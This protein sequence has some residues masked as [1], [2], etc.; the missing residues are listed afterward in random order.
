MED[1]RY[2]HPDNLFEALARND[3][4]SMLRIYGFNADDSL[5]SVSRLSSFHHPLA[6]SLSHEEKF[7]ESSQPGQRDLSSTDLKCTG[8]SSSQE[9]NCL[10]DTLLEL[11]AIL[12]KARKNNRT[13]NSSPRDSSAKKENCSEH[14]DDDDINPSNNDFLKEDSRNDLDHVPENRRNNNVQQNH[15]EGLPYL[16]SLSLD[17]TEGSTRSAQAQL[18]S[19]NIRNFRRYKINR[20]TKI[21]PKRRRNSDLNSPRM[22]LSQDAIENILY[23]SAM[24]LS[25]A[26]PH[27]SFTVSSRTASHESCT[28]EHSSTNDHRQ[29]P[30]LFDGAVANGTPI[31][32]AQ[33]IGRGGG[34]GTI[35]HLACAID[36]PF[37]LA[38]V[39]VM[40]ADASSRHT[41]FRRLIIHE[42]ACCDSPKCLRL[43][44]EIGKGHVSTV[45]ASETSAGIVKGKETH[46]PNR[47]MKRQRS[48]NCLR[49]LAKADKNSSNLS[50]CR[51]P[52]T[53]LLQLA[54]NLVEEI[55]NHKISDLQAAR[56]L[57]SYA[58]LNDSNKS[59][60]SVICNVKQLP[61]VKKN[62]KQTF[63]HFI[64][65]ARVRETP[66]LIT[67]VDGHG[68][69]A[70]HWA[71]FKNSA[72][73]VSLL[74]EYEADPNSVA[75][76]T[77]WTP[78]HDAAYSDS[79]DS[80]SILVQSGANVNA[81]AHSGATP[82]CF[83]AQEDS[84]NAARLLIDNG[85]DPSLRCCENNTSSDNDETNLAQQF[86][87]QQSRFSGYTPLH[88]CAHYNSHRAA[89]VLLEYNSR[90]TM[91]G[92]GRSLL[93]IP[94]LNDKLAIHIVAER[95]SSEVLRELLHSGARIDTS[96]SSIERNSNSVQLHQSTTLSPAASMERMDQQD[97]EA[98]SPSSPRAN[99]ASV[100]TP[101]SS[102][103]LRSLI[104]SE[105]VRSSKPWNCLSQ[106]S[107]DE[108][109][110]LLQE[111]ESFWEPQR[112]YIFPTCDRLSIYEVLRVG[113]RLNFLPQ[114]IWQ[115]ILGFCGRGW[116]DP[117]EQISSEN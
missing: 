107:I 117:Y 95:G 6:F 96:K 71:S 25:N 22:N 47:P 91:N 109:R 23:D 14:D 46:D 4:K 104:P 88:Y 60:M 33:H 66:S 35:Q 16:P 78:L 105:P 29:T 87:L 83:A 113:V 85:A 102:P 28:E 64:S 75:Q 81:R 54:L 79:A 49:N 112:H 59:V 86:I 103:I 45:S 90:K 3:F 55:G 1:I 24:A 40:G 36:S 41:A 116:F 51:K 100:V 11:D 42:A 92:S 53:S 31:A 70:L 52:F 106:S 114:E 34:S 10:T 21:D 97:I 8:S 111:A 115:M 2:N 82:L 108:C 17:A 84:P 99:Q 74:F 98:A 89:L 30:P 101:I 57:L 63:P 62:P 37:A 43:L 69:T 72:A 26:R 39:L 7:D 32:T 94:D 18:L 13:S 61:K 73:C 80:I 15:Q 56:R 77:G 48:S 58:P 93:E 9:C 27:S 68:N 19:M 20:S 38:L 44:L 65:Y 67:N 110:K 76:S 12:Q 5:K 50:N